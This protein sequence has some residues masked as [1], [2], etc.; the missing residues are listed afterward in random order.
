MQEQDQYK[1]T[2]RGYTKTRDE[3]RN[4]HWP[5]TNAEE[6]QENLAH[7]TSIPTSFSLFLFDVKSVV[8]VRDLNPA[9]E[10]DVKL[11]DR[12]EVV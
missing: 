4:H 7:T 5:R 9:D 8:D 6:N 2:I 10:D 1:R 3:G 11:E 12:G